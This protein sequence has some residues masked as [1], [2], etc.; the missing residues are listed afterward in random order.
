MRLIQGDCLEVMQEL[1]DDGVRVDLI[2]TDPPYGTVKGM[3]L[4][5]W[6]KTSTKWDNILPT[7]E[8]FKLCE[9]LLRQNGIMILF[10]QEPYT[11]HLRNNNINNLP[12]IYP[13]IWVKDHFANSLSCKKAPVSYFEDINV[14]RKK[15]DTIME[16]PLRDYSK[17]VMEYIGLNLKQI[18]EQ[19]GHR[20]AEHFFYWNSSQFGMCTKET[21]TDLIEVF[22][23]DKMVG[24]V[25]YEEMLSLNQSPKSVFNLRGGN[26]KSNI[27]RFKKDYTNFH[28]TQK[29]IR[30]LVDLIKTYTNEGDLVLDFTMG[31]GS[32]GVACYNTGRDFIGIELDEEYFKV[33]SDRI[34]KA[35]GQSKLT[36]FNDKLKVEV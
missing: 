34:K 17:K 6:K 16:N 31:S 30:L 10:S 21:Y 18:N 27:L 4:D 1:A 22:N 14:F 12:F 8:M 19:L 26:F 23:I 13:L 25:P 9:T 35:M 2:L 5:G 29:P 20:K 36:S 3:E 32:T 11:N 28:P 7:K 24:F 33:A 15:Y